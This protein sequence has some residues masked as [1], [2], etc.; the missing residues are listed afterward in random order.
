MISS[1]CS[2]AN[3][4]ETAWCAYAWPL[5]AGTTGNYAFFI[6][7]RGV[8]LRTPMNLLVYSGPQ[9][10]PTFSAALAFSDMTGPI[11]GAP[12]VSCDGNSWRPVR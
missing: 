12:F 6:N 4:C 8:L 5:L 9:T 1:G 10:F 11:A 7:Q 2:S 3:N